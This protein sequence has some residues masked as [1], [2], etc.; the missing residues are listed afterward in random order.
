MSDAMRAAASL[1]NDP[2]Y[3]SKSEIRIRKNKIRRQRIIRRQLAFIGTTVAVVIFLMS[4]FFNS[5]MSDAQ[6]DEFKPEFKYYKTVTVHADESLWDIAKENYPEDH[7]KSVNTYICEI[8]TINS[9]KD[10][11]KINAGEA[12]II[13]YYSSE[14]K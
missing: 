7:Y 12:L 6:S 2:R 5:F 9:I 10:A 13:P 4:L 14:F 3:F 1:Y 11:G 8:C